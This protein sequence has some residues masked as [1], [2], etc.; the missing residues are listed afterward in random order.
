VLSVNCP[1]CQQ[2]VEW[3]EASP[4][5]PFCSQRCKNEDFIAWAHEEHV[6]AGD[7][8]TSDHFSESAE[9]PR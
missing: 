4:W 5:R 2:R 6:L 3:S 9:R 1:R 8:E 7:E